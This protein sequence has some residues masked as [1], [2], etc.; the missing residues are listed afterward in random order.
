MRFSH[1][2]FASVMFVRLLVLVS[3]CLPL[4]ASA[5]SP[6]AAQS[7]KILVVGGSGVPDKL[8]EDVSDALEEAG[9]VMSSAGY[10][11]NLRARHQ[12]PDSEEALT[13]L[14]P[15]M[16]AA[17]IVVLDMSRGKL[18]VAY[19]NGHTGRVIDE[20][21]V[22]ARGGKRAKLAPAAKRKIAAAAK[23][24]L[25]KVGPAP[26]TAS[27]RASAPDPTPQKP[28]RPVRPV[29]PARQA[30]PT[31]EPEED[32]EESEE[33]EAS[34]EAQPQQEKTKSSGDE[35][36]AFVLN[37][38]GGV[39]W[40]SIRVPT[41]GGGSQIDTALAP[42]LDAALGVEIALGEKWR[43]NLLAEYR[44]LF[45]L[46]AA[47]ATPTGS[48]SSSLSSHSVFAGASLGLL[49]NGPDSFGFHV[50][51]GWGYR[52]L[53]ASEA[54][55]PS[56]SAQGPAIRPELHIPFGSGV[57]TLRLAPE[58]ILIVSATATLP[59][60]VNGLQ[61]IGFAYGGE[62][63]LDFK[64]SKAVKL[65]VLFRESQG[66]VASGWGT[67]MMENERYAIG[68]LMLHL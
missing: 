29:A 18:D 45:G 40:R 21:S 20:D 47:Y 41:R 59:Q 57:V 55:L 28:A 46:S 12:A 35:G 65:S 54:V 36:I 53:S 1:R 51:L 33:D 15:Q 68:R 43:V 14:A 9:S 27:E 60:N 26:S 4:W 38:G 6:A 7:E 19:R 66:T 34:A 31:P 10:V 5:A 50:Y 25:A 52:G 61:P 13:K 24:A 42:A 30:A 16:G 23:H 8:Q 44:T 39:G 62:A 64:I 11:G 2:S 17:L 67:S 56:A 3:V 32:E 58:F 22:P 37:A 48:A 49:T 63:S